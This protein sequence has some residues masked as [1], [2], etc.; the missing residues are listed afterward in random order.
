[1]AEITKKNIESAV[2]ADKGIETAVDQTKAAQQATHAMLDA[3]RAAQEEANIAAQTQPVNQTVD[4]LNLYNQRQAAEYARE[5]EQEQKRLSR[6][7]LGH[8]IASIAASIG[9]QMR[10]SEG[11]PVS[12]RDWQRIYDNL[13]AQERANIDNYR[14][15]MAKLHEDEKAARMAQAQAQAKA[16]GDAQKRQHDMDKLLLELGW[17]GDE[18]SKERAKDILLKML[19]DQTQLE[20]IKYKTDHTP[21]Q[22]KSQTN[23]PMFGT[24]KFIDASQNDNTLL[25][26]YGQIKSMGLDFGI[27]DALVGTDKIQEIKSKVLPTLQ[28]AKQTESGSWIVTYPTKINGSWGTTSKELT[29]A[30]VKYLMDY[31]D[32]VSG[33]S[34]GNSTADV[35]STAQTTKKTPSHA[36]VDSAQVGVN[37]LNLFIKK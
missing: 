8:D 10:A 24:V 22:G 35:Q 19:G 28:N 26:L 6:E 20:G 17:K 18:A 34:S 1:M 32:Q 9:D 13:T 23:I 37:L 36:P 30:Q 16:V 5:K 14:V 11:A 29:P 4:F 2:A 27:E 33:N 15:R 25:A 3:T 7:R 12:P 21:R 31:V